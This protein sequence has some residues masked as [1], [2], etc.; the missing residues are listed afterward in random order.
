MLTQF[1]DF[2]AKFMVPRPAAV[3]AGMPKRKSLGLELLYYGIVLIS[4]A[5][6]SKLIID[7]LDPFGQ[8]KARQKV[9]GPATS[10]FMCTSFP[11]S[12]CSRRR[13]CTAD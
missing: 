8:R 7:Q 10:T 13:N 2:F 3:S 6:L 4:S 11:S 9:C 12:P 5:A 1:Q